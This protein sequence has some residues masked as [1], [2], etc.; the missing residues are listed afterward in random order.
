MRSAVFLLLLSSLLALPL[1]AQEYGH[2]NFANLL[3]E[4]PGT[5]AAEAELEA[6]NQDLVAKGEQ[7]VADFQ[8]G[9]QELQGQVDNLPPVKLAEMQA[10]LTK[11]RDAIGVYEQE[12]Q[13]KLEQKRQ[14]L[15]GPLIQ[16]ARDA[17][18]TVA[19]REGYAL[20]FDTSLFNTILFAQDADDLMDLVKAELGM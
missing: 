15:L 6:Y 12:M 13:V 18:D 4:M 5:K 2:L 16:Q 14:E 11:S 10:E 3:S 8:A 20:V 9:V 19:A 1:G 17:I 7:M